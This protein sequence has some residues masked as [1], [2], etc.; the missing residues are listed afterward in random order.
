MVDTSKYTDAPASNK[1]GLNV[2]AVR[3]PPV[4]AIK[5]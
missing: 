5:F 2:G 1:Q 4:L 3:E